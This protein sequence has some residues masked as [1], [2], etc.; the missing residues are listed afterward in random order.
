MGL[1]KAATAILSV[2]KKSFLPE[3]TVNNIYPLIPMEKEQE[4]LRRHREKR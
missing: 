4:H 1:S 3:M 2:V